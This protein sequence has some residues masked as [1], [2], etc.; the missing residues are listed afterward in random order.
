M[1]NSL[2]GAAAESLHENEFADGDFLWVDR[3]SKQHTLAEKNRRHWCSTARMKGG[4]QAARENR[5]LHWLRPKTAIWSVCGPW[6]AQSMDLEQSIRD[7]KNLCIM[8]MATQDDL[9]DLR[10]DFTMD[11]Y[12][13]WLLEDGDAEPFPQTATHLEFEGENHIFCDG[14][15][16]F[17]D[18]IVSNGMIE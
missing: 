9:I 14:D 5:I 8:A 7:W 17:S 18:D 13:E 15:I 12:V 11:G 1:E 6:T 16:L 2:S 3:R 4:E 10:G